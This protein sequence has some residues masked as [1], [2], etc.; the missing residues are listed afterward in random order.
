[1]L[2]EMGTTPIDSWV[3]QPARPIVEPSTSEG[4]IDSARAS[5]P[6]AS[7]DFLMDVGE[8]PPLAIRLVVS[9]GMGRFLPSDGDT[10]IGAAVRSGQIIG[11]VGF[12]TFEP[13]FSAFDGVVAG[14]L[15]EPG[16]QIKKGQAV[17]WLRL[18]EPAD[19]P[20]EPVG[21]LRTTPCSLQVDPFGGST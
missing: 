14:L 9:P 7:D 3:R 11:F 10:A 16:E 19:L 17:A 4:A 18:A 13:I 8:V 21:H 5:G 20:T 15:A 6:L 2:V 1:M 12:G